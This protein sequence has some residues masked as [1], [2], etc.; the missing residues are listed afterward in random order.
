LLNI[1]TALPKQPMF[2][3]TKTCLKKQLPLNDKI[4]NKISAV[5]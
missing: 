1:L 5:V 4:V 2:V 3:Y